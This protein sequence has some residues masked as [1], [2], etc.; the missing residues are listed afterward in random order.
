ME[1]EY[2]CGW[3]SGKDLCCSVIFLSCVWLHQLGIVEFIQRGAL[4]EGM[5][6]DKGEFIC[7]GE[8]IFSYLKQP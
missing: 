7:L 5:S 4:A 3:G 6:W 2:R 1:L 8:L